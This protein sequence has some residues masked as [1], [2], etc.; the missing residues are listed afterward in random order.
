MKTRRQFSREIKPD[1]VKLVR[2]RGVS[3]TEAARDV[4]VHETVLCK[5]VGKIRFPQGI[6][7]FLL[8]TVNFRQK[9]Q[10]ARESRRTI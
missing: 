1:T 9:G 8:T 5:W 6:I 2:E 3:V 4:D 10:T 7:G